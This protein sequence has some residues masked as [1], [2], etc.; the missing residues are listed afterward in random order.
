MKRLLIALIVADVLLTMIFLPWGMLI[1]AVIMIV[2]LIILVPL[3][4]FRWIKSEKDKNQH[5]NAEVQ[6]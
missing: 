2:S 4:Y 3:F 5:G 1:N 6:S